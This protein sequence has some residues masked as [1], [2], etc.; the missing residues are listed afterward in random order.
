MRAFTTR[1]YDDRV[2]DGLGQKIDPGIFDPDKPTTKL[3][4]MTYNTITNLHYYYSCDPHNHAYYKRELY[5]LT[6]A[7]KS[8]KV[9]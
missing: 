5:F 8:S 9:L 6:T 2:R 1:L 7:K 3:V 4:G